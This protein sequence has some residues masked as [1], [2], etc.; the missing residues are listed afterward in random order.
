MN[1]KPDKIEP[2][3]VQDEQLEAV[4]KAL[5][6]PQA[7]SF[8]P[9]EHRSI[10]ELLEEIV[11]MVELTTARLASVKRRLAEFDN[12]QNQFYKGKK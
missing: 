8:A 10:H 7:K 3:L 5:S 6:L 12:L 4:E 9:P 1:S 2:R 11:E